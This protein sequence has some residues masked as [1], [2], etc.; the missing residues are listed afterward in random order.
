MDFV[1]YGLCYFMAGLITNFCS[2][3]VMPR[4]QNGSKL[5]ENALV[6]VLWPVYSIG[7]SGAV[8]ACIRNK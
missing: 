6:V 1:L 4:A 7:I 3:F 2:G 5:W 8:G